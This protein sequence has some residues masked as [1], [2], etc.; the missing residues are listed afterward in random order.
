MK[1]YKWKWDES[2]T[3]AGNARSE[4]PMATA[5]YFRAGRE[6]LGAEITPAA[7]HAFR[8]RT[9]RFRYSLELFRPLYGATLEQMIGSLRRLQQLLGDVND[10][11]ASRKLVLALGDRR[12]LPVR[13]LLRLLERRQAERTAEFGRAWRQFD[14]PGASRR[15]INYLTA[16][17]GRAAR[18]S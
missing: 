12:S 3:L 15:W 2:L 1:S 17:P 4:L 9:K 8:L 5:R 18:K 11:E 7:L 14:R 10:C 6:I 13:R 16:F